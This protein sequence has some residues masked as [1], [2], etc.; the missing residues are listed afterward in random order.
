MDESSGACL[1]ARVRV[2]L[3]REGKT[4]SYLVRKT[5]AWVSWEA[6]QTRICPRLPQQLSWLDVGS[7][8]VLSCL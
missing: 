3:V 2:Q 6:A 4:T 7:V 5:G 1:L 8:G